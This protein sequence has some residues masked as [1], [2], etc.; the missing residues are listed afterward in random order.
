MKNTKISKKIKPINESESPEMK[1]KLVRT[2]HK[3]KR[4]DDIKLSN[5]FKILQHS[6]L[7][8]EKKSPLFINASNI[9][10]LIEMLELVIGPKEFLFKQVKENEIEVQA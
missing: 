6:N 3:T 4:L 7:N 10:P 2:Q 1:V 5:R 8:K 9:D